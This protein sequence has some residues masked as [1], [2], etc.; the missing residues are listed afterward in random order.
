MSDVEVLV[1]IPE[2]VIEAETVEIPAPIIIAPDDSADQAE[3]ISLREFKQEVEQAR[4][5]EIEALAL[6][7]KT[8][9]E[10]ALEAPLIAEEVEVI[11][12]PEIDIAPIEVEPDTSPTNSH[13]W[14]KTWF[15]K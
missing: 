7:A 14:F 3:L 12:E 9:A 2:P 1:N 13:G 10:I 6:E 11:P 8:L 4:L 15:N 5:D